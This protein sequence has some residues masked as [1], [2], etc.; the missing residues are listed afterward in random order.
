[1]LNFFYKR[2][3][4]SLPGPNAKNAYGGNRKK[5]LRILI[6]SARW[7]WVVNLRIS[8]SNSGGSTFGNQ[9]MV[10]WEGQ[11]AKQEAVE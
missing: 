8:R 10:G 1:M 7:R 2:D 3:N 9:W 5:A 6:L 11:K 4:I